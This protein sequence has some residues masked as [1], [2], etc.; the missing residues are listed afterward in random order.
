M[1]VVLVVVLGGLAIFS[2]WLTSGDR[3][4]DKYEQTNQGEE[5]DGTSD[6]PP[7]P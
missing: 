3:R 7:T 5:I 4:A 6:L 2:V 1:D